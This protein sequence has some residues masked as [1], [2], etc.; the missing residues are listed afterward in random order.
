M[1]TTII[2]TAGRPDEQSIKLAHEAANLLSYEVVE[3]KKRS[4]KKMQEHYKANVLVAGKERYEYFPFGETE[5]FF[6]HPNSASFRVKRIARGEVDPLIEACALS[7]GDSFLDCTLGIGADSIVASFVVGFAGEIVGTEANQ[8]VAFVVKQG[9]QH[10]DTSTIPL[11]SCMRQ[12]EVVHANA[13][14]YLKTQQDNAF[15]VVYMDPMFEEIIEE[16]TNF[17]ALRSAGNHD[18]LTEEWVSEAMR[19]ARKRVVLK[20]HFESNYFEAFGFEQLKRQTAKFHY[21]MLK[22]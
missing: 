19:V 18:A 9:M 1:R 22:V 6:F 5:P 2:T 11:T 12:V 10:Y 17:T 8:N 21:G 4:V 13:I 7:V 15:D 20:A 3:R 16:S 14:D